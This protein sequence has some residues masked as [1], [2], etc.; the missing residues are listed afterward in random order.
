MRTYTE[1][2]IVKALRERWDAPRGKTQKQVATS[3]GFS[4]KFI[5]AVLGGTQPI[6]EALA[7]A[8]GFRECPRRFTRK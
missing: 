1:G 6:T 8:L 4:D 5:Y 2:E 7:S 3:L